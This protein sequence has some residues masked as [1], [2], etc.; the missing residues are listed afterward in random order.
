MMYMFMF[1]NVEYMFN[2]VNSCGKQFEMYMFTSHTKTVIVW[3]DGLLLGLPHEF[4][5]E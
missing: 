1:T 5:G 2:L 4:D 3:R